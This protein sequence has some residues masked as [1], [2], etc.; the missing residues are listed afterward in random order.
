[1]PILDAVIFGVFLQ[2]YVSSVK[3][4][5]VLAVGFFLHE[6]RLLLIDFT[7][8]C[9]CRSARNVITKRGIRGTRE[10]SSLSYQSEP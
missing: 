9:V 3:Y 6:S 5:S 7:A 4:H 10:I 8:V 1:M 2:V